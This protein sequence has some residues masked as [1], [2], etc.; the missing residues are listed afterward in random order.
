MWDGRAG[1]RDI[2]SRPAKM[3]SAIAELEPLL[4]HLPS[5]KDQERGST[6]TY[7]KVTTLVA[8]AAAITVTSCNR[9]EPAREAETTA[10]ATDELQERAQEA[11]EL[12]KR[13]AELE[14]RLAE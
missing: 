6:M 12:D 2:D 3:S 14:R 7:A 11:A 10:T 13:A 4:L 9:A 5:G 1:P 8:L